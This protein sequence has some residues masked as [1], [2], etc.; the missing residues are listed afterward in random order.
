MTIIKEQFKPYFTASEKP[1]V[2]EIETANYISILGNGSPGTNLFYEKKH[3]IKVWAAALSKH[4]AATDKA[5]E[6]DIVEIFY[7][8]DEDEVGYVDIGNFYTTV[9]L[10]LLQ[11]RIVVRIPDSITAEEVNAFAKENASLPFAEELAHYSYTAGKSVQLLHKGPFA[12]ELDTLP[13]LQKFAT[14]NGY[15]KHGMHHEIHITHFEKGQSQMHLK[16]IL[17]DPVITIN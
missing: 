11:Y 9:D 14:E 10:S 17:R 13:I 12:N 2:V 16:T 1:E 15:K 5:F 6:S 3:A 4:F 8:F 7:W